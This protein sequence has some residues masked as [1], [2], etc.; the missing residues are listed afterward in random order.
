MLFCGHCGFSSLHGSCSFFGLCFY[1]GLSR[2]C[3]LYLYVVADCVFS[4]VEDIV[5][6]NNRMTRKNICQIK[7]GARRTMTIIATMTR[8]ITINDNHEN[9]NSNNSNSTTKSLSL[10]VSIIIKTQ[11]QKKPKSKAV[12]VACLGGQPPLS[13]GLSKV[14]PPAKNS[15]ATPQQRQEK[16]GNRSKTQLQD[17][18]D[19]EYCTILHIYTYKFV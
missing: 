16:T 18:E 10:V 7:Q 6:K 17:D 12:V 19:F 8:T 5:D 3:L 14:I 2:C 9:N 13:F 4:V 11:N 1:S 15:A